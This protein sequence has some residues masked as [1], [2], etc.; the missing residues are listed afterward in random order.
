M[1]TFCVLDIYI[2]LISLDDA[3]RVEKKNR[4]NEFK[5]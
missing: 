4:K 2:S 5:I 1:Q 3:D